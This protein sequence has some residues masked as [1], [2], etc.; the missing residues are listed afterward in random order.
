M[1]IHYT[2]L[3]LALSFSGAA[4]LL[5]TLT[6]WMNA[7]TERYLVLGAIGLAL[8]STAIGL[9]ALRNG[10]YNSVTLLVPFTLLLAGFSFI[11]ASVRKFFGKTS[12]WPPLALGAIGIIGI[13]IPF[14][15]GY[16]GAGNIVLNVWAGLILTLSGLEYF[17]SYDDMR[18][19]MLANGTLYLLTALTFFLC[20]G[21]AFFEL[22][23]DWTLYPFGDNWAD[24]LNAVMSLGGVTGIGALTLVLHFA[25]SARQ[26]QFAANTDPLTGVLNRRAL[27]DR[28]PDTS[29]ATELAI[30]VFDLDHFKTINDQ[31]GHAH[32]DTTLQWFA[33]IMR[34]HSGPDDCVARFGGEEFC[35]VLPNATH[36]AASF[37]ADKIR[38]DFAALDIPCGRAGAV[39]TVSVGLA[40]G[41]TGEP[42]HSVLSRADAA[43]YKA[44]HAGRNAVYQADAHIQAA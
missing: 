6:S 34:E 22:G 3:L 4:L 1:S 37:L 18:S 29:D 36:R 41:G 19:A 25:R 44:K 23:G 17:R 31:L 5:A 40:T 7:R 15:T 28:Y 33:G 39:A 32:G 26:Q 27:F 8:A 12:P 2:S 14:G 10:V 21:V 13:A 35:M 11:Y 30:M 43:L 16:L 24:N 20:A 38:T 42:F 9:M